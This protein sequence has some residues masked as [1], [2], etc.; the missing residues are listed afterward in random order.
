LD[1]ATHVNDREGLMQ[2]SDSLA[3]LD[4][5]DGH[6]KEAYTFLQEHDRLSDSVFSQENKNHLAGVEADYKVELT[7]KQLQINKLA[8]SNQIKIKWLLI[9]SLSL[10]LLTLVLIFRQSSLRKRNNASLSLLNTQLNQANGQLNEVNARLGDSNQQLEA[11]NRVKTQFFGILNHDLRSPVASLITVLRLRQREPEM[12]EQQAVEART[13]QITRAAE[14]LLETMEDLLIWS[15]GQMEQFRPRMKAV[16]VAQLFT[17]IERKFAGEGATLQ[18]DQPPGLTVVTD[19]DFA[20]TILRN[21]TGNAIK[22]L[23]DYAAT[24]L[25]VHSGLGLHII[26]DMAKAIG[27]EVRTSSPRDG[28]LEVRLHFHL[29][30]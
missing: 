14:Q 17:D 13:G 2:V 26:R 12:I 22:A 27:C 3:A 18:F 30:I 21:L 6:F 25:T 5:L 7:D 15:K 1:R 16:A 23:R 11:A 24:T 9:S 19:E 4:A 29:F 20:K 8:L 10:V 28:G